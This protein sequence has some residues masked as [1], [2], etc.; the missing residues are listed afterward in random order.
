MVMFQEAVVAC[1]F[2]GLLCVHLIEINAI[3]SEQTLL[4]QGL[5]T[6]FTS[7]N[8]GFSIRW[9]QGRSGDCEI[10]AQPYSFPSTRISHHRQCGTIITLGSW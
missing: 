4:L 10:R 5:H 6:V 9:A 1:L 8:D 3:P 7:L 2:I